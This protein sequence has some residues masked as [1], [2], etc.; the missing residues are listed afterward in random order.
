MVVAATRLLVSTEE[1]ITVSTRTCGG[2]S[3]SLNR[4]LFFPY[5]PHRS[6]S[7][8][9]SRRLLAVQLVLAE[10]WV[11]RSRPRAAQHPSNVS[12]GRLSKL[13][14][15]RPS[16]RLLTVALTASRTNL[17]LKYA[18]NSLLHPGCFVT[19]PRTL[20]P[21]TSC[22][23]LLGIPHHYTAAKCILKRQWTKQQP[24]LHKH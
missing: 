13:K 17:S 20:Q 15:S 11:P 7:A 4:S 9:V 5:R 2:S 10:R 8:F 19:A 1:S 23:C 16:F 12:A 18:H 24:Q 14:P 21:Q 6:L 3:N 22:N